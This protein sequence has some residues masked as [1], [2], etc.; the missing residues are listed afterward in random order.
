MIVG[1]LNKNDCFISIGDSSKGFASAG[2]AS[3][4]HASTGSA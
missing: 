3:T 4:G 1:S 2:H